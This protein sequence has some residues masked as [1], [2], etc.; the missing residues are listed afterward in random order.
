MKIISIQT[1]F[2][3]C[4]LVIFTQCSLG[5]KQIYLNEM[6]NVPLLQL[7]EDGLQIT[8]T[9]SK[10]DSALLLYRI[11][12]EIDQRKKVIFLKGY[13]ALGKE[14]K[15]KFFIK[16]NKEILGDIQSFKIYWVDPDEKKNQLEIVFPHL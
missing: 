9:N 16:L 8:T 1:I 4:S 13:Q 5:K 2:I 10:I 15:N 14:F 3:L 6:E 7:K 12:S 11:Q